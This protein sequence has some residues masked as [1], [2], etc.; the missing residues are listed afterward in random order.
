MLPQ[1]YASADA[2]VFSSHTETLGLVILE[3]MASGLPVIAAPVGGVADHLRDNV[4]G[5]AY[6]AGDIDR[7]ARAMTG[8][9]LSPERR[10]ELSV[11]A[12]RTAEGLS[13][14]HELDRLDR[15]Y[16][17]VLSPESSSSSAAIPI[18]AAPMH[19]VAISAHSAR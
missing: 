1:L 8:I 11:G 5:I 6:P 9:A 17:E 2:F 18:T 15:S 13:W 10:Y 7:M 12:R 14:E 3:A 16:R 19:A 4:N